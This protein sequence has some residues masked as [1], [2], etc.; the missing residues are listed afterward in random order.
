MSQCF[1]RV[2]RT[3]RD[4]NSPWKFH[5]ELGR[6]R[7]W[8]D[9]RRPFAS[10]S[11]RFG[12]SYG[13]GALSREVGNPG[14]ARCSHRR[15]VCSVAV[16]AIRRA[17]RRKIRTSG[18]TRQSKRASCLSFGSSTKGARRRHPSLSL[19]LSPSLSV[20]LCL[21]RS[22]AIRPRLSPP[23][24]VGPGL[25]SGVAGEYPKVSRSGRRPQTSALPA[26]VQVTISIVSRIAKSRASPSDSP[27]RSALRG[28][29]LPNEKKGFVHRSS[30]AT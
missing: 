24:D 7:R 12:R 19:F 28:R 5:L 6:R 15:A 17:R 23:E 26:S 14:V 9:Y 2:E 25:P 21:S 1:S 18:G 13:P 29:F 30:R 16:S 20:S 4:S 8:L 27:S 22:L 11:H 3:R 10:L